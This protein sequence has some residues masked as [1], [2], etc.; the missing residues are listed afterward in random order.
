MTTL[1]LACFELI[2]RIIGNLHKSLGS[3]SLACFQRGP[4]ASLL[5][6]AIQLL[7]LL[8]FNTALSF[9]TRSTLHSSLSLACFQRARS[10][11]V[12]IA[13]PLSLACFQLLRLWRGTGR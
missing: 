6:Q 5:L 12:P 2:I 10:A 11:P 8:V 4:R 3:L 1:S 13:I 9:F 7:V